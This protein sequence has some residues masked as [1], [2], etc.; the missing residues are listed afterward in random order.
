MI[1]IRIKILLIVLSSFFITMGIFALYSFV[2]TESYKQMRLKNI[3]KKIQSETEIVNKTIAEIEKCAIHF[4][5]VGDVA[6]QNQSQALGEIILSEFVSSF[7]T[8]VGGGFWFAPYHYDANTLRKGFYIFYD[9]SINQVRIDTTFFLPEYD[10]HNSSWYQEITKE[11]KSKNQVVWTKPYIDGSGSYS[12]MTTAGA[13]IF[14]KEGNIIAIST[15]DWRIEEVI[16]TLSKIKPTKGSFAL[17]YDPK[18]DNVISKSLPKNVADV[19]FEFSFWDVDA[20]FFVWNET[21]YMVFNGKMDNNWLLCVAVPTN[22]IFA[23]IEE[24]NFLYSATMI[25]LF[26][27]VMGVTFYLISRFI[28]LPLKNL[29]SGVSDLRIGN[30]DVNIEAKTKDEFGLLAKTFNKMSSELKLA[31]EENTRKTTEKERM[32]AELR[33]ASQIQASMLPSVFPEFSARNEFKIYGMMLPA[34]DVGGDFY[35]FFM[36]DDNT[37]AIVIADVSGKG[38]PAA[39]FMINAKQ[40]IKNNARAKH[41]YKEPKDVF[42]TV[43]N[44]LCKNNETSMFV[45]A[46]IGYLNI[47]TGKFTFV[48]AGHLPPLCYSEGQFRKLQTEKNFVLGGIE[49]T[50]YKQNEITLKPNDILFLY[51]DGVTEAINDDDILF[52]ETRLIEA[53]NSNFNISVTDLATHIKKNIDD[54]TKN[55]KQTDDIAMLV[56]QYHNV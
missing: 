53:I 45:T 23:D 51:T 42:E 12:L 28:N 26:L 34:K 30:F 56:L 10:Y 55:A 48:N 50:V 52:G 47:N 37:L 1:S 19:S 5:V 2:T 3:R 20:K 6:F 13:G 33:I 39:L 24:R 31:I 4:A 43:N 11:L 14:D 40:L 16:N 21:K 25:L 22:E 27:V 8:I 15:V 9:K 35:D 17:L 46:F 32:D 29:T 54:F 49:N 36:I 7:S 18:E 38:I 41:K 44:K